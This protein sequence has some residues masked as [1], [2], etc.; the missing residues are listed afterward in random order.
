MSKGGLSI[1]LNV[2]I[3]LLGPPGILLPSLGLSASCAETWSSMGPHPSPH[4]AATMDGILPSLAASHHHSPEPREDVL[5]VGH[6]NEGLRMPF[7]QPPGCKTSWH[8]L[9]DVLE[10]HHA[11]AAPSRPEHWP[12][13]PIAPDPSGCTCVH[14]RFLQHFSIFLS[15]NFRLAIMGAGTCSMQVTNVSPAFPSG[16]SSISLRVAWSG[17]VW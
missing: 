12:T 1:E 3:S 10:H 15:P 5:Q 6:H 14:I 7:P 13:F 8:V 9:S 16:A 11:E 17:S 2:R 4:E